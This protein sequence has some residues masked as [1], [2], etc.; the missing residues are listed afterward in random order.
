MAVVGYGY[1]SNQGRAYVF[2]NGNLTS[3]MAAGTDA[4]VIITGEASTNLGSSIAAGDVDSDGK[5]DLI[6]GGRLYNSNQGRDYIFY[7]GNLTA[8][9]SAGTDADVIISGETGTIGRFGVAIGVG[10]LDDDNDNDLVIGAHQYSTSTGRVYIFY[11]NWSIICGNGLIRGTE[12]CD[13]GNTS[14]SDGTAL[15]RINCGNSSTYTWQG[16]NSTSWQ[17]FDVTLTAV[18]SNLILQNATS[19]GYVEYDDVTVREL[20]G[21]E[22]LSDNELHATFGDDSTST[23]FPTA[24]KKPGYNFDGGDYLEIPDNASLAFGTGNFTIAFWFARNNTGAGQ[25]LMAKRASVTDDN[26]GWLIGIGDTQTDDLFIKIGDGTDDYIRATTTQ[27]TDNKF[28][29]L[30]VSVNKGLVVDVY[31]DGVN[32]NG[33]ETGTLSLVGNINN[34]ISLIIGDNSGLT[35]P[36][37]GKITDLKIF[38]SAFTPAQ[39][40]NLF[41]EQFK[42]F[43]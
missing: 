24:L 4:D 8:S 17:Y 5:T 23:T 12:V 35:A 2:Y 37:N 32:V 40:T 18:N 14:G 1:N 15:P 10:D 28:H 13:D 27:I 33:T 25:T 41:L 34:A 30:I 20:N 22:D 43:K 6:G 39:S 38:D 11:N 3:S 29:H 9:M 7:N 36:F 21:I 26:I 19:S 16:T 31:V 42:R